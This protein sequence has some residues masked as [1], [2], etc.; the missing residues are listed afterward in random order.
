MA[1][2]D[3]P[4]GFA[5]LMR[6]LDGGHSSVLPMQK[7][8]SGGT[9]IFRNDIVTKENDGNIAPGGTPG[10]TNY[11]GVAINHGAASTLTD[12]TVVISPNAMFEGQDNADTDGLALTDTNLRANAEF[13]AGN[14]ST[15]YS[16]HEIDESTVATT[17]SLDLILLALYK[18]VDNAYGANARF[19]VVINKHL[20]DKGVTGV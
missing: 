18:A 12:H 15:K 14:A 5:P 13:N 2:V 3:N 1:N 20:L 11:F 16:G 9:A 8:A 19:V 10:T 4:H 17:S 6:N 7:D